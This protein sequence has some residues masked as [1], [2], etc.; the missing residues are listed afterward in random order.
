[1]PHDLADLLDVNSQQP[2][3]EIRG[4]L[5]TPVTPLARAWHQRGHD[6]SVF[7][8]DPSVAKEQVLRGS[9]LVI[10]VLPKRRARRCLLDFY[11]VERRLLRR[12]I[13]EE[14]PEVLSAQWT[15]EHALA[16]LQSG[17][18]TAVT[19]HDTPL[20]Y[21]WIGK[22]WFTIYHLFM[23]WTVIR[24][25]KHLVCV[26]PYTAQHIRKYFSP[27]CPVEVVPNGMPD[28]LF[29]RGERRLAT[30]SKRSSQ[31]FTIC[32]AGGWAD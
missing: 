3:R 13:L 20:R 15:Y 31:N 26:S 6:I 21:A 27:R 30:S 18:P 28:K 11:S 8:L 7:C 12:A 2:L 16:A 14:S 9:R 25:A 17:I 5:A 1:M 22:D 10:H 32:S 24:K 23:A 29:Q 19:C 4:V